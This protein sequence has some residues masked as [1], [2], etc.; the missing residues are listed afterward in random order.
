MCRRDARRQD[1]LAALIDQAYA[2]VLEANAAEPY[3]HAAYN[4]AETRFL[5]AILLYVDED[6]EYGEALDRAFRDS[7]ENMHWYTT[8]WTRDELVYHFHTYTPKTQEALER[9]LGMYDDEH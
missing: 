4:A 9:R 5:A 6:A 7:M 1:N 2:E 3:S 8:Q